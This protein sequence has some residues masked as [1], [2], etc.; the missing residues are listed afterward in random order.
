MKRKPRKQKLMF[1]D[2]VSYRCK[3]GKLADRGVVT[4]VEGNEVKVKWLNIHN[5]DSRGEWEAIYPSEE[6]ILVRE[7]ITKDVET[8][9]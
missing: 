2:I 6:L 9:V 7:A 4:E 3:R 8:D 5:K 1:G